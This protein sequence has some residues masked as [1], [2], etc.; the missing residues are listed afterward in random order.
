MTETMMMNPNPEDQ[1]EAKLAKEKD[2]VIKTLMSVRVTMKGILL[3]ER[4]MVNASTASLK[5]K[6]KKQIKASKSYLKHLY[7]CLEEE[8]WQEAEA[9]VSL[10][11]IR[12]E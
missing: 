5:K 9:E 4:K 1:A 8:M 11:V 10:E 7:S 3:K 12:N 2:D 6:Y